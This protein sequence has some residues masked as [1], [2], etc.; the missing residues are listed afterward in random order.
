M[1]TQLRCVQVRV[2]I[3]FNEI[4]GYNAII[5]NYVIVKMKPSPPTAFAE[6]AAQ[7]GVSL[8]RL[9]ERDCGRTKCKQLNFSLLPGRGE[10]PEMRAK[11]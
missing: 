6:A 7:V 11:K 8:P 10:E 4:I 3:V 1:T 5:W 9:R 2:S